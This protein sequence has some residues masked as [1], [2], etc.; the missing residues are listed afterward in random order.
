MKIYT[1]TGDN[2]ETGFI[3]G[4][5]SKDSFMI[6]ALGAVDELNA[7]IGLAAA[8]FSNYLPTTQESDRKTLNKP[9]ASFLKDE[10][11][12][13]SYELTSHIDDLI[14]IQ[15]T[16][17]SVGAMIAGGNAQ[18][19]FDNL[20]MALEKNI[21]RMDS[22]LPP[23]QNFILPGGSEIA[24]NIHFVRA[25]CRRTERVLVKYLNSLN[26]VNLA[27]LKSKPEKNIEKL[28]NAQ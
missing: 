23:L 19:D 9:E 28:K 2:G 22:A 4:R 17:F 25:V 13:D 16:L 24:A 5:T 12:D 8:R 7:V 27:N 11:S 10:T 20:I 15:N 14:S 3:G 26:D 18:V 21:D 1:K 6:D